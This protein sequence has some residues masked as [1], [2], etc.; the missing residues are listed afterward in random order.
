MERRPER[1]ALFYSP[2]HY[3]EHPGR[4]SNRSR[5]APES[6]QIPFW[7]HYIIDIQLITA[8]LIGS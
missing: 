4:D 8:K 7:E 1:A 5:Y 2:S 3:Q 6:H